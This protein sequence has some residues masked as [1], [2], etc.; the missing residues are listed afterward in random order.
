M[1]KRDKNHIAKVIC[2]AVLTSTMVFATGCGNNAVEVPDNLD[3][4]AEIGS[5]ASSSSK[6]D[7]TLKD[8][9]AGQKV[10]KVDYADI[11]KCAV[12][13]DV[14]NLKKNIEVYS[15]NGVDIYLYQSS[16]TGEVGI[17][18]GKNDILSLNDLKG[19]DTIE[20]FAPGSYEVYRYHLNKKAPQAK[21][22]N[23]K[24][25]AIVNNGEVVE[26][27]LEKFGE[28]NLLYVNLEDLA[29]FLNLTYEENNGSNPTASNLGVGSK[30]YTVALSG[31]NCEDSTSNTIALSIR[32]MKDGRVE[33]VYTDNKDNGDEIEDSFKVNNFV[34]DYKME[35][36]DGKY[37]VQVQALT[38]IFGLHYG[39]VESNGNLG[40]ELQTGDLLVKDVYIENLKEAL[41]WKG[42]SEQTNNQSETEQN[43]IMKAA[44][45]WRD[46]EQRTAAIKKYGLPAYLQ[47]VSDYE[48][49]PGGEFATLANSAEYKKY[50][51]ENQ[52]LD[53]ELGLKRE[54]PNTFLT[55]VQN[56]TKSKEE[57]RKEWRVYVEWF[58][59]DTIKSARDELGYTETEVEDSINELVDDYLANKDKAIGLKQDYQFRVLGYNKLEDTEKAAHPAYSTGAKNEQTPI[60][61]TSNAVPYD[62]DEIS[63]RAGNNSHIYDSYHNG[64]LVSRYDYNNSTLT[65]NG[66]G[67][68]EPGRGN[69]YNIEFAL[70][71]RGDTGPQQASKAMISKMD[72]Y[73][74]PDLRGMTPLEAFS[75]YLDNEY[76]FKKEIIDV[77]EDTEY[78]KKV[79][80]TK[81][82][83]IDA[84]DEL[85][86]R[87]IGKMVES[88]SDEMWNAFI[89]SSGYEQQM[90]ESEKYTYR[91]TVSVKFKL[92]EY[93]GNS[94]RMSKPK[95]IDDVD[96]YKQ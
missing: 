35:E 26:I 21:K 96:Y 55:K 24:A 78:A 93:V 17:L 48:S 5:S 15:K 52:K 13:R 86:L 65:I 91:Q 34:S 67:L 60:F 31:P 80:T 85:Y 87:V 82:R 54:D 50:K 16:R 79:H 36:K 40:F 64:V 38:E 62:I 43:E 90:T 30:D 11:L 58:L 59:E 8:L 61:N 10:S 77:N 95:K 41:K 32:L 72:F 71:A 20:V 7:M 18:S 3:T 68:K 1:A 47:A 92:P 28:E 81:F 73:K 56:D 19:K 76:R 46:E 88:L 63:N 37:Y 12:S 45:N 94:L 66:V 25:D 27:R 89:K 4:N 29:N 44:A 70:K 53:Y 49:R 74:Y 51:A 39:V 33:V 57:L 9:Y 42:S 2:M 23:L 22:I 14:I 69:E 6:V 83:R 84:G 75:W